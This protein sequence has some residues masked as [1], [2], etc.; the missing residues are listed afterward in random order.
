MAIIMF[1]I[2]KTKPY[3]TNCLQ[4]TPAS[5]C[6]H[7]QHHVLKQIFHQLHEVNG[8]STV[9]GA[10]R[11]KVHHPIACMF[12]ATLMKCSIGVTPACGLPILL[13]IQ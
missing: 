5:L 8:N 4:P 3:A 11:R 13:H 12:L 6:W 7:T 2:D 10:Y 9:A 1:A